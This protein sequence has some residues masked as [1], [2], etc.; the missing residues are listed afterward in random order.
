MEFGRNCKV[1]TVAK[2]G[3]Q[4][5]LL[6]I[7]VHR[8]N[9]FAV[10][11]NSQN[12]IDN[13]VSLRGLDAFEDIGFDFYSIILIHLEI[14]W[15]FFIFGFISYRLIMVDSVNNLKGRSHRLRRF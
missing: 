1:N 4:N 15:I 11:N 9:S 2:S 13:I 14:E 7:H 3:D 12:E 6:I 10:I 5:M 8:A